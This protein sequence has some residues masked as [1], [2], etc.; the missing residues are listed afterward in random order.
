MF[1]VTTRVP[2]SVTVTVNSS[3]PVSRT[4]WA[5]SSRADG[6]V[7][8]LL[9]LAEVQG[10]VGRIYAVGCVESA[11][12]V[13]I[14]GPQGAAQTGRLAVEP[15]E[16]DGECGKLVVFRRGQGLGRYERAGGERRPGSP[17]GVDVGGD[18]VVGG[19]G[20]LAVG[21]EGVGIGADEIVSAH[22][23]LP[24][25]ARWVPVVRDS[26]G[27]MP[28]T[29]PAKR[30]S[31]I[32]SHSPSAGHSRRTVARLPGSAVDLVLVDVAQWH[33]VGVLAGVVVVLE[34]GVEA[35]V[36]LAALAAEAALV[37]ADGGAEPEL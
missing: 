7:R 15:S 33:P 35:E 16:L 25:S 18:P 29:V 3:T 5:R 21:V 14:E 27:H 37:V 1:I 22:D 34:V 36:V 4:S 8:V 12:A 20:G 32:G 26:P 2:P 11:I 13:V 28:G 23:R 10:Q 17:V 30:R 6:A 31:V 19:G 24:G 9:V